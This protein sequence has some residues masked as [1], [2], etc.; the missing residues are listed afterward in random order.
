MTHLEEQMLVRSLTVTAER[1]TQY[2]EQRPEHSE[3]RASML[4]AAQKARDA[5]VFI[6]EEWND[7]TP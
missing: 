4:S 3:A 7:R 1:L 6:N 5:I 2:A